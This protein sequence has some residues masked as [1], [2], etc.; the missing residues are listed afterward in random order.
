MYKIDFLGRIDLFSPD[1]Y[2][3]ADQ[4][5]LSMTEF[6]LKYHISTKK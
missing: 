2:W 1:V 3:K 5:G 4:G 6:K